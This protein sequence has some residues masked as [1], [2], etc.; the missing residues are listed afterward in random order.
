MKKKYSAFPLFALF[1][2]SILTLYGCGQLSSQDD[3]S[4]ITGSASPSQKNPEG[5]NLYLKYQDKFP[6]NLSA[7]SVDD[8]MGMMIAHIIQTPDGG[9]VK[10]YSTIDVA[11]DI[12]EKVEESY[13]T[14]NEETYANKV[15]ED[16]VKEHP[17]FTNMIMNGADAPD[18]EKIDMTE[19][20]FKEHIL[21]GL[22]TKETRI[23]AEKNFMIVS[24]LAQPEIQAQIKASITEMQNAI[25]N[26]IGQYAFLEY[27][28]QGKLSE[29]EIRL[30]IKHPWYWW[31][32]VLGTWQASRYTKEYFNATSDRTYI[33]SF[34]HSAWNA[35]LAHYV[36][37]DFYLWNSK[38]KGIWWATAFTNAHERKGNNWDSDA[39]QMDLHNNAIGRSVFDRNSREE[40][41]YARVKIGR[42]TVISIRIGTKVH[43][44][45]SAMR[46]ELRDMANNAVYIN[47]GDSTLW[48]G[49]RF[50]KKVESQ[51][52]GKLLF[53]AKE[54]GEHSNMPG[55][56]SDS[57]S[58][59][60]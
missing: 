19:D 9:E 55:G 24:E 39:G 33:N 50:T 52:S 51:T 36:S 41:R 60:Y 25:N 43:S 57:S 22:K 17:A 4:D 31:E 58:S 16:L 3:V 59:G 8:F 38:S 7:M 27:L 21:G 30:L 37:T 35:H 13:P 28:F 48:G 10:V 26:N 49:T 12:V 42:W 32:T 47:T 29:E 18:S 56:S 2:I 53:I 14:Y 1:V 20:E 54:G 34:Q 46:S 6:E 5:G 23:G 40:G 44:N 15:A 45:I 11:K